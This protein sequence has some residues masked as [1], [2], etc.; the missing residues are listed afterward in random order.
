MDEREDILGRPD[1]L[2]RLGQWFLALPPIIALPLAGGV[3]AIALFLVL[4]LVLVKI[5]LNSY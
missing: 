3:F 5:T 4:R 2:S 1:R